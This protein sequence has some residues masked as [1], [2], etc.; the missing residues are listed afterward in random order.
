MPMC[1]DCISVSYLSPS[2][3][4]IRWDGELTLS[5][6]FPFILSFC[7][8]SEVSR[9]FNLSLCKDGELSFRSFSSV[10]PL[11]LFQC[12]DLI[13]PCAETARGTVPLILLPVLRRWYVPLICPCAFDGELSFYCVPVLSRLAVPLVC[14]FLLSLYSVPGLRWWIVPLVSFILVSWNVVP[15]LQAVSISHLT[16]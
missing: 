3:L 10:C 4:Y 13:C 15:A 6:D 1:W 5:S 16:L 7:W 2:L 14:F 11:N 12:T 9:P 8:D